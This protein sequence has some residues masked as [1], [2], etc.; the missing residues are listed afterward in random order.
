MDP[1][2]A[3]NRVWKLIADTLLEGKQDWTGNLQLYMREAGLVN[4]QQEDRYALE[5]PCGWTSLDTYN[6]LGAMEEVV[7]NLPV[8]DFRE[9]VERALREAYQEVGNGVVYHNDS[10]WAVG[11]KA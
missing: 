4:V 5:Q 11:R 2:R 6:D 8:S 10:F 7:G 1:S 9:R 3:S